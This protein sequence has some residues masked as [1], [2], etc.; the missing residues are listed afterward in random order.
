MT[1]YRR[2]GRSTCRNDGWGC[3]YS[4]DAGRRR[5]WGYGGYRRDHDAGRR[6]GWN[7][8]RSIWRQ[9]EDSNGSSDNRDSFE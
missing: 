3:G 2:G 5:D 9:G 4:R 6:R 1:Y 8:G 7:Y